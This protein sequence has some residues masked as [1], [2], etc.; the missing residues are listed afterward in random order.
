MKKKTRRLRPPQAY[1]SSTTN[2]TYL[3]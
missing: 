3:R 2:S 1:V